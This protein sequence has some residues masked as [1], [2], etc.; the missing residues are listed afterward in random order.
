MG[1]VNIDGTANITVQNADF[2]FES[3]LKT[4]GSFNPYTAAASLLMGVWSADQARKD[5]EE[6][7]AVLREISAKLTQLNETA[8]AILKSL[9][10][11]PEKLGKVLEVELLKR[12]LRQSWSRVDSDQEGFEN[13][14]GFRLTA[15]GWEQLRQAFEFVCIY[16]FRASELAKL[17]RAAEVLNLLSSGAEMAFVRS[18]VKRAIERVKEYQSALGDQMIAAVKAFLTDAIE[19]PPKHWV[20]RDPH[21]TLSIES[22]YRV[23]GDLRKCTITA[24]LP[25]TPRVI[26]APEIQ[27]IYIDRKNRDILQTQLDERKKQF[28][29]DMDKMLDA[30]NNYQAVREPMAKLVAYDYK[31]ALR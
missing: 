15:D 30:F 1:D 24:V 23:V 19:S 2:N 22:D 8:S 21:M 16:E 4:T 7:M 29:S 17:P 13:I 10:E 14:Q 26:A 3:V 31:K 28:I 20:M 11:L 6:Q 9:D 12:D 27:W 25:P 5:H 18:L